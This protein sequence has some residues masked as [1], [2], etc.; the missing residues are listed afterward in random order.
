[1]NCAVFKKYEQRFS[2]KISIILEKIGENQLF[3]S[4]FQREY[5]WK[6]EDAKQPIDSLIKEYLTWTML[7]RETNRPTELKGH[8]IFSET[9]GAVRLL[10][11]GQ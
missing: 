5:V 4:A 11:D 9:G 3:V 2:M 7:T 8:H 1:M 10:L 6:R